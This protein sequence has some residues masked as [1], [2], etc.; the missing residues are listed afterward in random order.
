[1]PGRQGDGRES[2]RPVRAGIDGTDRAAPAAAV[3]V[4]GDQP[5]AQR[6]VGSNLQLRVEAGAYRQSALVQHLLAIARQEFAAYLLGEIG[7]VDDFRLFAAALRQRL[8]LR[9]HVFGFGRVAV[10]GHAVED[11]VAPDLSRLWR[12]HRIVIV[13]RFWKPGE[14]GRLADGQ[15]VE[16]LVEIGQRRGRHAIGAG[17]EIDLVQIELE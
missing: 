1:G 8:A 7:R 11:P 12:A 9:G 17:A 4:V 14:K 2:A 16:L 15:F 5:V 3:A 13:R 10:L 6:L